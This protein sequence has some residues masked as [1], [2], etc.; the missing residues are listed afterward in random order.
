MCLVF[1]SVSG[2]SASV[3]LFQSAATA[4]VVVA[5]GELIGLIIVFIAFYFTLSNGFVEL[6]LSVM[7]SK[8]ET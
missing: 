5:T 4:F 3:S 6:F 8:R 1:L 2:W 7:K